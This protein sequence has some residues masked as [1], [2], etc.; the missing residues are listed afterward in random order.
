VNGE[1]CRL[2]VRTV[3]DYTADNVSRKVVL[4][5]LSYTDYV[6]RTGWRR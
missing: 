5:I 6:N 1:R 4:I 3:A 2:P